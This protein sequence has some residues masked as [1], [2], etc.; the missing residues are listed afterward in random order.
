[1]DLNIGILTVIFASTLLF[2]AG[3]FVLYLL[4]QR[5]S[6]KPSP[7]RSEQKEDQ[8]RAFFDRANEA[9]FVMRNGIFRDCN[10][11]TLE[12]FRCTRDDILGLSPM[13]VSPAYQPDGRSSAEAAA[14]YVNKALVGDPQDFEWLHRRLDGEL[15]F[16]NVSLSN[17]VLDGKNYVIGFVRDMNEL[18]I[19]NDRLAAIVAEQNA[20]TNSLPDLVFKLNREGE[21][22]WWNE[23]LLELTG[24]IES[25]LKMK[26]FSDLVLEEDRAEFDVGIEQTISGGHAEYSIRVKSRS[27]PVM[28]EFKSVLIESANHKTP[29]IACIGRNVDTQKNVEK[30]LHSIA[31]STSAFFGEDFFEALVKQL[32][33]A[34]DVR[35]AFVGRID[36]NNPGMIR[37]I[38]AWGN[39]S[40]DDNFSFLLTGTP[41][42]Y[43][44]DRGLTVFNEDVQQQFPADRLLVNLDVQSYAGMPLFDSSGSPIG[45]LVVMDSRPMEDNLLARSVLSDFALRAGTELDRLQF[46]EKLSQAA[47][48][49]ESSDEGIMVTDIGNS[50][51]AINDA[52]TRITGYT[53]QE[54]IGRNPRILRSDREPGSHYKTMWHAIDTLGKWQG[55]VW[56]RRKDGSEFPCRLRITT[57]RDDFGRIINYVGVFS[58]TSRALAAEKKQRDL[59]LQ[60]IQ[61]QKMEA[62]GQLTG[63]IAHDF[64]NILA[65][66]LGYTDLA[67]GMKPPLDVDKLHDYLEQVY[68]A[69]ER[70]R[71]LIAQ[72]LTFSRRSTSSEMSPVP[73]VPVIKEASKMLRP[74]LSKSISLDVINH[75]NSEQSVNSDPVQLHQLIVNLCVNARDAVGDKGKIEIDID[76]L[77]VSDETCDSCHQPFSGEYLRI[78]VRDDGAGMDPEVISQIFEPFFTTKDVGKGT[79]MGLST[80][81]GIV[82]N[83][84]GHIRV[85]SRPGKGTEFDIFLPAVSTAAV[86][87]DEPGLPQL[88]EVNGR[89]QRILVVDDEESISDLIREQLTQFNY[90]ITSFSDGASALAH[91]LKNMDRYDLVITDQAMPNLLGTEMA[92]QMLKIRPNLPII[93]C[94]GHHDPAQAGDLESLRL[95]AHL[96]KP[97]SAATLIATVS[98]VLAKKELIQKTRGKVG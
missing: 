94:T 56:N 53:E 3:G 14:E 20:I 21:L 63:G 49:F 81:H 45:L 51:V 36:R 85:H 29:E 1:M 17:V 37:T 77:S 60:L 80:V 68:R 2:L 50:I 13:E 32:A 70:A 19:A 71:D 38:A 33:H 25:E 52:F 18:K 8:F 12:M 79:G 40:R 95:S 89:H 97:V 30:V 44:F 87:G 9:I 16:A 23:A 59:E 67:R 98:E 74:M 61:A 64:N 24:L 4:Q 83:H 78:G 75:V 26:P 6:A 39:G 90:E 86:T 41:S 15:F 22:L 92:R 88:S 82:H 84:D 73:L 43:V 96:P 42:E 35:Y 47:A 34:L 5:R 72:M 11:K 48:V 76:K 27:E 7:A 62:L 46:E 31:G 93:L 10:P 54:V 91:F 69:G 66:I 65:S 28:H 57:V 55:D 58:D